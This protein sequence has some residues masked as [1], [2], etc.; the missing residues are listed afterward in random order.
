MDLGRDKLKL[1]GFLRRAC[2]VLALTAFRDF[3]S[4]ILYSYT[5]MYMLSMVI[6][7]HTCVTQQAPVMVHVVLRVKRVGGGPKSRLHLGA[8]VGM[9]MHITQGED[10]ERS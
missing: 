4:L 10:A 8:L 9:P 7:L 2:L 1:M 5:R 6:C 3:L